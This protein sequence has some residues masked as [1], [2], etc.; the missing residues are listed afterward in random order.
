MV[1]FHGGA[2]VEGSASEEMF[3]P[4]NFMKENV[5]LIVVNYRLGFLGMNFI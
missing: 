5:I 1:F 4:H 3:N 2:F